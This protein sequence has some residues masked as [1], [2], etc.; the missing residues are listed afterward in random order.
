MICDLTTKKGPKGYGRYMRGGVTKLAHV[1]AW[2]DAHGPVP[3]G[4]CVLHRCDNPPCVNVNHLFLGTQ[5][6]N[7]RDRHAKGRSVMP[8]QR[9]EAHSQAR[10]C[11]SQ[12]RKLRSMATEGVDRG[13][14][15]AEFGISRNHVN[16]IVARRAWRH[17]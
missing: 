1:W 5:G 16:G 14:L 2:E 11:E 13:R 10:L 7:N 6:D 9:G 3:E 17:A 15:A 8:D 12:V 4:L